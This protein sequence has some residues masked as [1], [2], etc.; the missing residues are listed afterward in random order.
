VTV[1]IITITQW[2]FRFA[3]RAEA[4]R[5]FSV[6]FRSVGQG[7]CRLLADREES[8]TAADEQ[9]LA[10]TKALRERI[11]DLEIRAPDLASADHSDD[12]GEATTVATVATTTTQP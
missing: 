11:V 9:A 1:A 2:I 8:E 3:E 12:D 4:H 7:L 5:V 6:E 10:A